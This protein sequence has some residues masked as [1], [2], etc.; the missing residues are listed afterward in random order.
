[1]KKVLVVNTS[2]KIPGGEDTNIVEEINYLSRLYE[3][4]YLEFKN[5]DKLN[6]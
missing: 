4:E 2:Y 6:V 3:I 5:S 1:M